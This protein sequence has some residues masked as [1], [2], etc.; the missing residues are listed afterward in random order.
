MIFLDGGHSTAHLFISLLYC[1]LFYIERDILHIYLV[2]WIRTKTKLQIL[3][4]YVLWFY[5]NVFVR[6]ICSGKALTGTLD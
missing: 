4:F 3:C 5:M 6:M 1:L 2:A